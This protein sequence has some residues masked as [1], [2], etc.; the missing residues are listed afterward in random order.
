[1]PKI[2]VSYRRAGVKAR[3]YRMADELRRQ[4]GDENVFVDIDS[5]APGVKFADAIRDAITSSDVVLIMIGPKWIEMTCGEGKRRLDDEDD[6]LRIEVETA[7]KSDALAIPVLV[8][9]AEVPAASDLPAEL[10]ELPD[11]QAYVLTDSHWRYDV[12]QLIKRIDPSHGQA[13]SEPTPQPAPAPRPVDSPAPAAPA[14]PTA[15]EPLNKLGIGSLVILV[16]VFMMFGADYYTY[17]GMVMMLLMSLGAAG[18]SAW[19]Y[20]KSRPKKRPN[21]AI[22]ITGMVLGALFAFSAYGYLSTWEQHAY[23][24]F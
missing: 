5:I 6:H 20:I 4:F 9:G 23:Y 24:G 10:A 11:L 13:P 12:K 22:L 8:N 17:G 15:K 14:Q 7:L 19:G 1:M 2:F 21:K 3:T 16:V 18:M